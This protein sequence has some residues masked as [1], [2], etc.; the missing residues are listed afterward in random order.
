MNLGD[1]K[2]GE[3]VGVEMED[4]TAQFFTRTRSGL[5]GPFL[6]RECTVPFMAP[7]L[8]D[9]V[10]RN[11]RAQRH[12]A[13]GKRRRFKYFR[14]T[15]GVE[16]ETDKNGSAIRTTPKLSKKE[17]KAIAQEKRTQKANGTSATPEAVQ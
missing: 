7:Q 2:I 4:G 1:I 16:Y 6:D 3:V 11:A 5:E 13:T 12:Y 14:M 10:D 8:R 17:R 9:E 15:D